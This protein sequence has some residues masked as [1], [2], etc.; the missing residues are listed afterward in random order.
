MRLD[1]ISNEARKEFLCDCLV[2][3][4]DKASKGWALLA[5]PL[6]GYLQQ[7]GISGREEQM[8][9]LFDTILPLAQAR[10]TSFREYVES[11][12][13]IG[14][15][16]PH[17]L[18][19][20]ESLFSDRDGDITWTQLAY[21]YCELM[22]SAGSIKFKEKLFDV[23]L[24]TADFDSRLI[25]GYYLSKDSM[26][27]ADK[28]NNGKYLQLVTNAVFKIYEPPVFFFPY[29]YDQVRKSDGSF[30]NS[31]GDHD[32]HTVYFRPHQ[33]IVLLDKYGG[34]EDEAKF[35][36][37]LLPLSLNRKDA[38]HALFREKDFICAIGNN[39]GYVSRN[40]LANILAIHGNKLDEEVKQNYQE[41]ILR[42]A[43]RIDARELKAGKIDLL[44]E[45]MQ[46]KIEALKKQR[47]QV[48]T[49]INPKIKN[50]LAPK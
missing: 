16:N 1:G 5:H 45:D 8:L 19:L 30:V 23:L 40:I 22:A 12:E 42:I 11:V 34:C 49:P 2:G 36:R 43:S 48:L 24:N 18:K 47:K 14:R 4:V 21:A 27:N 44:I 41:A 39:G 29:Y 3:V 10:G 6:A 9:A 28:E 7:T 38:D 35:D 26:V 37:L 15:N 13:T 46:F 50:E 33:G 31:L 25:T 32:I 17:H 20:L